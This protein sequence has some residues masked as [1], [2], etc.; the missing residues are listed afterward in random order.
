MPARSKGLAGGLAFRGFHRGDRVPAAP[1]A[2]ETIGTELRSRW[3]HIV[4][5]GH[6]AE[7]GMELQVH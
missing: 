3:K 7:V 1:S 5:A 2:G 6:N 4:I